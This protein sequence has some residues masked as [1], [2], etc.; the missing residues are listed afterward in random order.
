MAFNNNYNYNPTNNNNGQGRGLYPNSNSDGYYDPASGRW[1]SFGTYQYQ[2]VNPGALRQQQQ[3]AEGPFPTY[4]L[5]PHSGSFDGTISPPRGIAG[6]E[7]RPHGPGHANRDHT[8]ATSMADQ[9][10]HQFSTYSEPTT[11]LYLMVRSIEAATET[12]HARISAF[13]T[14]RVCDRF[15]TRESPLW[16]RH[17]NTHRHVCNA[18]GP[19]Y[20]NLGREQPE[21]RWRSAEAPAESSSG[22]TCTNCVTTVVTAWRRDSQGNRVCNACGVYEQKR[23]VPRPV[24]LRRDSVTKRTRQ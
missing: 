23:G 8:T 11:P 17:P 13:T 18:C 5:D 22:P 4:G 6:H 10:G 12:D 24:H 19:F 9:S 2:F 20:L 15:S 14:G 21:A 3:Q 16:R 1:M 7:F